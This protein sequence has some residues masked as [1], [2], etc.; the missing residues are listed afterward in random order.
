MHELLMFIWVSYFIV[1]FY[2]S[3]YLFIIQGIMTAF[4]LFTPSALQ[5]LHLHDLWMEV[6]I[7]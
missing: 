2:V 3:T 5:S 1:V 7:E 6:T 4:T